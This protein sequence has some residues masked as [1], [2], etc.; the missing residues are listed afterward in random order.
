VR[1]QAVLFPNGSNAVAT[2]IETGEIVPI[3]DIIAGNAIMA[4]T[5]IQDYNI[6]EKIKVLRGP[7]K[8]YNNHGIK[9]EDIRAFHFR[10]GKLQTDLIGLIPFRAN[11]PKFKAESCATR[12]KINIAIANYCTHSRTN[13]DRSDIWIGNMTELYNDSNVVS[14]GYWPTLEVMRD[15]EKNPLP[16]SCMEPEIISVKPDNSSIDQYLPIPG[17][18]PALETERSY[19]E[20]D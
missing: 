18:W 15:L 7:V 1:A 20:D 11:F 16:E 10:D 2:R 14:V 4:A 3:D 8:S 13:A 6:F 9:S 5:P 12:L 17:Y 19:K